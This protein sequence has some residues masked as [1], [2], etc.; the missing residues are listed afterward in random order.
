MSSSD[1]PLFGFVLAA[2]KLF[3]CREASV[4]STIPEASS[5]SIKLSATVLITPYFVRN[6]DVKSPENSK[7]A[8]SGICRR[9][10]RRSFFKS[11]L[12][13]PNPSSIARTPRRPEMRKRRLLKTV[14]RITSS[15][16]LEYCRTS[17]FD[18]SRRQI[19]SGTEVLLSSC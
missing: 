6:L 3:A 4:T 14:K 2:D 10:V 1:N 18:Q 17:S 16:G 5:T 7:E 12:S 19:S 13:S 8:S 11:R 15:T 9:R